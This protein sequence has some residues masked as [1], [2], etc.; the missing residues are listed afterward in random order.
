MGSPSVDELSRWD[1]AFVLFFGVVTIGC[2]LLITRDIMTGSSPFQITFL[3]GVMLGGLT[4]TLDAHPKVGDL[5]GISVIPLV[6]VGVIAFLSG[7]ASDLPIFFVI[8]TVGMLL[9]LAWNRFDGF[10]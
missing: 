2:I 4:L 9:N 10:E 3:G 7:H 6:I 8:L 1:Y 5:T